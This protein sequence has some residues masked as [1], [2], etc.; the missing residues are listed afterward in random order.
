METEGS[1][2]KRRSNEDDD[3]PENG[4]WVDIFFPNWERE[5]VRDAVLITLEVTENAKI[6][7][8]VEKV[9]KLKNK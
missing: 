9:K 6:F 5:I 4:L 8:S 7:G 1:A 3:D 2:E